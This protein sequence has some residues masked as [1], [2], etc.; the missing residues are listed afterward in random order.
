MCVSLPPRRTEALGGGEEKGLCSANP[1]L[2]CPPHPGH[3]QIHST[4]CGPSVEITSTFKFLKI[5]NNRISLLYFSLSFQFTI[6]IFEQYKKKKAGPRKR[7]KD[8]HTS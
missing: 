2:V 6:K 5:I 7:N 4:G 3:R 8:G 1:E